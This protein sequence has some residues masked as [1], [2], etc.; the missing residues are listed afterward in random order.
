[1]NYLSAAQVL[2]IHVRPAG[3]SLN[4]P[5]C[6]TLPIYKT[7]GLVL[8]DKNP[9]LVAVNSVKIRRKRHKWRKAMN[10]R[11]GCGKS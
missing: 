6:A 7:N 11:N 9:S 8:Y 1:M 3:H 10:R 4:S 5:Q 2:F